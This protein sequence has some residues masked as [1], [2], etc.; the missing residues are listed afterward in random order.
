MKRA[1][2]IQK[3]KKQKTEQETLEIEISGQTEME[4]LAELYESALEQL[5]KICAKSDNNQD[6]QQSKMLFRGVVHECDKMIRIR[7]K[8]I[9]NATPEELD[10]LQ[11]RV[12]SCPVLPYDFH[13]IYAN[14][15]YHL[16]L[17]DLDSETK[18]IDFLNEALDRALFAITIKDSAECHF[19][20]SRI[21]IQ[22]AYLDIKA[23]EIFKLEFKTVL[24][25]S[26][27]ENMVMAMELAH[28]AHCFLDNIKSPLEKIDWV[29]YN[30]KNWQDIIN[31]DSSSSGGYIGLGNGYLALADDCIQAV[32]EDDGNG[33]TVESETVVEYLHKGNPYMLICSLEGIPRCQKD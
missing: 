15:L 24:E 11:K 14:A 23:L 25:I 28:H 21:L 17:V 6:L 9:P 32:E 1:K 19:A 3:A 13:I 12:E 31:L 29:E 5:S 22:K 26:N 20:Y 27:K 4:E 10:L 7:A 30:A 8:E 2:G 33:T 18:P 16:A